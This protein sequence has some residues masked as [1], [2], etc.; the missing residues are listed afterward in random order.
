MGSEA[1]LDD[2]HAGSFLRVRGKHCCCLAREPLGYIFRNKFISPG[3]GYFDLLN[4]NF[5]PTLRGRNVQS[6]NVTG[7]GVVRSDKFR[8]TATEATSV[9]PETQLS[10]RKSAFCG[11]PFRA[12]HYVDITERTL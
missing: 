7:H 3:E 12:R 6:S 11:L 4:G 9:I 10:Y 8:S 2:G 5:P 1:I